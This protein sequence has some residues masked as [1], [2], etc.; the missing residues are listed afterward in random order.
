MTT[1]TNPYATKKKS[2]LLVV[3]TISDEELA[4]FINSNNDSIN[5]NENAIRYSNIPDPYS[6]ISDDDIARMLYPGIDNPYTKKPCKKLVNPYAKKKKV[7]A[8]FKAG[9]RNPGARIQ[10]NT[11]RKKKQPFIVHHHSQT[12]VKKGQVR[13]CVPTTLWKLSDNRS[14]VP[15]TNSKTGL[16]WSFAK[17]L[18]PTSVGKIDLKRMMIELQLM[19]FWYLSGQSGRHYS[20]RDNPDAFKNTLD[21][22]QDLV[23]EEHDRDCN[24]I[25]LFLKRTI[26]EEEIQ[27]EDYNATWNDI[28]QRMMYKV[29]HCYVIGGQKRAAVVGP[30]T[31]DCTPYSIGGRVLQYRNALRQA[32][33]TCS[34]YISLD[35]KVDWDS[36]RP[37]GQQSMFDFVEKKN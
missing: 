6:S 34:S 30:S 12:G 15:I 33:R 36:N 19:G 5:S 25:F 27:E 2:L 16:V 32:T 14:L 11:K 35:E 7:F 17:G 9:V 1:T 18:E 3:E 23:D 8:V 13:M 10:Q 31:V 28:I 20:C 29:T 22:L 26:S 24:T 37:K 4:S 21:V